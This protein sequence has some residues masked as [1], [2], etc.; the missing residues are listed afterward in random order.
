M[1]RRAFDLA[2]S[3][4][5]L[6][7]LG[8]PIAL[9]ALLIKR[10]SKG[11]VFFVQPR[12]GRGGDLFGLY[13]FRTMRTGAS[14]PAVTATGDPRITPLGGALRR[15]KIDEIPQLWNVLR[16]DMSIVGPRPE[17]EGFVRHYTPEQREILRVKPGLASMAQLVFPHEA[18]ELA[19][20]SDPEKDYL[21]H[22]MPRKIAVDLEYERRRTL[23]SDVAFL[24]EVVLLVLGFRRHQDPGELR[25]G[26]RRT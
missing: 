18:E 5:A 12:V 2:V 17:V 8:I 15:W 16:G 11:P 23:R 19:S 10:D 4:L 22:W 9:I 3:S 6:A 25:E 1:L 14:G 13:K 24:G 7:A 26:P 21:A 20:S